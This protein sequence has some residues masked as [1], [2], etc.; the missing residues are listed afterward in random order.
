MWLIEKY[1]KSNFT[2]ISDPRSLNIYLVY[3]E[4]FIT[5]VNIEIIFWKILVLYFGLRIKETYKELSDNI[6]LAL[7]SKDNLCFINKFV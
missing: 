2:F 5:N 3:E 7:I 4:N 1:F 6:N